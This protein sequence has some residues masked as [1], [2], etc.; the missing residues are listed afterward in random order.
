MA[1]EFSFHERFLRNYWIV[2]AFQI[3][4]PIVILVS[5]NSMIRGIV[6]C[7]AIEDVILVGEKSVDELE[8]FTHSMAA[9]LYLFSWSIFLVLVCLVV[10]CTLTVWPV[11]P[12]THRP[13]SEVQGKH[14]WLHRLS[15]PRD[16]RL[17]A[18]YVLRMIVVAIFIGFVLY[19]SGLLPELVYRS[20][21]VDWVNSWSMTG[22]FSCTFSELSQPLNS[23]LHLQQDGSHVSGIGFRSL[24]SNIKETTIPVIGVLV[25]SFLL[26]SI[27]NA[28]IVV[29]VNADNYRVI[30]KK[31][32]ALLTIS[33]VG[34]VLSILT[35]YFY[36]SVAAESWAGLND[37]SLIVSA[38]ALASMV[39]THFAIVGSVM[40]ASIFV[41]PM[42]V[43]SQYSPSKLEGD[44]K[45][46]TFNWRSFI[47]Q[48]L[49][50]LSPILV[51]EVVSLLSTLSGGDRQ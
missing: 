4:V 44:K 11:S 43:T 50:L 31:L 38:E 17:I 9:N 10:G 20:P 28:D 25:L 2:Y 47:S 22:I 15:M 41:L 6:P 34:I 27:A 5:A 7:E 35:V 21:M 40:L 16:K 1:T 36:I 48:A 29:R 3:F 49:P 46:G 30:S 13:T 12:Q 24:F 23:I 39:T 33:S 18:P 14:A 32:A 19:T 45:I 8:Y 42:F 37:E 26:L 51:A